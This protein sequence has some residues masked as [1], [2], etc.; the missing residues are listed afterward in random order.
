[1]APR[2]TTAARPLAL[3]AIAAIT[4]LR[5]APAGAAEPAGDLAARARAALSD[6]RFQTEHPERRQGGWLDISFGGGSAS[7]D[8][9]GGAAKGDTTTGGR[10]R[11]G[12]SGTRAGSQG[13]G[14]GDS[15]G[16]PGDGSSR[17]EGRDGR[18]RGSDG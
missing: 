11:S 13:S 17:S 14:D 5:A 15:A 9:S 10:G 3:V 12:G 16:E 2:C 1:M 7:G 6:K 8:T 4:L 18:G